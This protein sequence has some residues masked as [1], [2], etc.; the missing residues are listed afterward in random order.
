M[1][2]SQ[3]DPFA[4]LGTSGNRTAQFG[5]NGTIPARYKQLVERSLF[6]SYQ[7]ALNK[8]FNETFENALKQLNVEKVPKDA[9]LAALERMIIHLADSSTHERAVKANTDD[10]I[11]AKQDK[12]YQAPGAFSIVG[13]RDVWLRRSLL[14]RNSEQLVAGALMHEAAHLAGAPGDFLAEIGLEQLGNVSGY[15]RR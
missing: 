5:S 11:A 15:V 9:Y 7:L 13:G 3:R 2:I 14:E 10:T 12:K 1:V 8:L 4:P 6:L